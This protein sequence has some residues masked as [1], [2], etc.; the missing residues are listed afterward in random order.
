MVVTY[1]DSSA[2]VKLVH[3]EPGSQPLRTWLG[4]R[5]DISWVS[6]VLAE[7]ESFRALARYAPA[8]VGGLPAV[9]EVIDLVDLSA[10]I[11]VFARAVRPVSIR[12]LDVIH[13]ATALQLRDELDAFVTYD[14]RLAGAAVTAGLAVDAPGQ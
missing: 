5:S 8:A 13:L 10:G 1:L 14:K 6:S 4:E 3:A 7:V 11:R 12:S 9:L 2:I